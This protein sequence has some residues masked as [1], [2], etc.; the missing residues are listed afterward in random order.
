[1]AGKK[2]NL[3]EQAINEIL[4]ADTVS[5][6]CSE[7]SNFEDYVKEEEEEEEDQ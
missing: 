5:E 3:D 2:I 4:F 7:A 6:S 1:M